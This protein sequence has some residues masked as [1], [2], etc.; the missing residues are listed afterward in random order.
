M[1]DPLTAVGSA[2]AIL[3]L[4]TAAATTSIKVYQLISTIKN[5]PREIQNLGRDINDFHTLIQ[6]LAEALKSAEIREL[7]DREKPISR[8][9]ADLQYPIVKCELSCI[10]VESKLNL[11]LQ[12]DEAKGSGNRDTGKFSKDHVWVRDWMWPIRRREVFQ[13]ISELQRT[14]LL[15]SDAMGSL[16]LYVLEFLW[17]RPYLTDISV[18]LYYDHQPQP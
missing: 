14:R 10:Q 9:V 13:L 3:Q 16:T 2:A 6:H 5:A 7:V 4:A 15:F 18:F 17:G 11:Q 8:A 1:G 12:S